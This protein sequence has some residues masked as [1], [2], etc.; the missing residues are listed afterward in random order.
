MSL[1]KVYQHKVGNAYRKRSK[2]K[3]AIFLNCILRRRTLHFFGARACACY[4]ERYDKRERHTCLEYG[5]N[6]VAGQVLTCHRAQRERAV[7]CI[8]RVFIH[9]QFEKQCFHPC[10]MLSCFYI[11]KGEIFLTI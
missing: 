9:F 7:G 4:K 3:R 2:F 6:T 11:H 8:L 1:Y 10:S 5:T